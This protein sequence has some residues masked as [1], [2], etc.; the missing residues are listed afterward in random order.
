MKLHTQLRRLAR[1]RDGTAMLEFALVLPFLTVMMVGGAEVVAFTWATGRVQDAAGAVGDLTAQSRFVNDGDLQ[2][3]FQA[4]D[5]MIESNAQGDAAVNDVEVML[6]S[7][8]ACPCEGEG[9]LTCYTVLWSHRYA[10]GGMSAGYTQGDQLT[11]V[12]KELGLQPN[13]SLIVTEV[14]Y[15][16]APKLKFLVPESTNLLSEKTFFRPR[17][18]K[19]V[20]HFGSQR[21]SPEPYCESLDAI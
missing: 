19:R 4:A 6:T 1:R 2:A 13:D 17:A 15:V 8:L 18:S 21:L 11:F 16:Y 20:P 5:A 3:I 12:P 10:S 14:E 7:V 9:G